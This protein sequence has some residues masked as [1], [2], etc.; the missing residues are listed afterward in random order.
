MSS[1]VRLNAAASRGRIA[2]ISALIPAGLKGPLLQPK[3]SAA[4]GWPN[5]PTPGKVSAPPVT[6]PVTVPKEAWVSTVNVAA[7]YF[8]HT[9]DT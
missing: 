2:S 3:M 6:W 8:C 1:V 7:S 4:D 9:W 5:E